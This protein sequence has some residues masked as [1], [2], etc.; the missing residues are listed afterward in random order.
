[1]LNLDYLESYGTCYDSPILVYSEESKGKHWTFRRT[2]D[3][4]SECILAMNF[5]T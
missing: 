4:S 1:M 2:Q 5:K 3:F